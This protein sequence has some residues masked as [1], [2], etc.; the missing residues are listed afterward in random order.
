MLCTK[1]T[2][3]HVSADVVFSSQ[4]DIGTEIIKKQMA[5]KI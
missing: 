4:F 2:N 1:P 3:T 5:K